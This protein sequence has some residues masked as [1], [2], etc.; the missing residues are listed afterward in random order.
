[1]VMEHRRCRVALAAVA[2]VFPL[3]A[4]AQEPIETA[5]RDTV[6]AIDASP[7]WAST[8]ASVSYDAATDTA[9]VSGLSV[10]SERPGADFAIETMKIAGYA[11][12]ANG[13]FTTRSITIDS[14]VVEA[15]FAKFAISD[16]TLDRLAAP[17]FAAIAF[18]QNKPFTSMMRIYADV[19][20]TRLASGQIGMLELV[21]Q[22]EGITSRASYENLRFDG[23]ADGKVASMT[24]GPLKMDSPSEQGLVKM[25]FGSVEGRDLDLAAFVHVYS[26]DSYPNGVGDMVWRNGMALAAYNNVEVEVPGARIAFG[27]IRL[28]DFRLRQPR[29]SFGEFFDRIMVNPNMSDH[30]ADQLAKAH[31]VDM[32]SAFGI[33]RFAIDRM[34]IAAQGLDRFRME[35]FHIS[36]LS[37]GGLGEFAIDG[38]DLAVPDQGEAVIGRFAFGGMVFPSP[39]AMQLAIDRADTDQPPDPKTLIP[40]LG[41]FEVL[42]LDL[43]PTGKDAIALGKFRFDLSDYLGV[44]PTR[45]VTEMV[46]LI[47][48]LSTIDD[49]DARAMFARLGYQTLDASYGFDLRWNPADETLKLQDLRA[50]VKG[51]GSL[52][53][54]VTL[55]G[56]PRQFLET[57]EL[58]AMAI[59]GLSLIDASFTF[60]DDSIVGKGL[61]LL[62]EQMK[63]PPDRFRQQ[64]ADAMPF[65][66]SMSALNDPKLMAIVQQSGLLARLAPVVK[67]FVASPGASV[68][69]TLAPP[70]P[71]SLAAIGEAS[72]KAPNTL[73]QVLGLSVSGKA[74]PTPTP[75]PAPTVDTPARVDPSPATGGGTETDP[76]RKPGEPAN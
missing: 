50:A 58:L 36:D 71:L 45:I 73:V 17:A 30:A 49:A 26:P 34:E 51:V 54:D 57:P 23:F 39:E 42:G 74:P 11:V 3:P 59:P 10:R 12:A 76:M 61:D 72:E 38:L 19:I 29:K 66:L 47:V 20:R 55:A 15:G 41:F 75:D 14:A 35:G 22:F 65:L 31:V 64:F 13:G 62:A 6:A 69:V 40:T 70:S 32:F 68:T 53:A 1:M 60:T 25:Q 43:R 33:G 5:I 63:A 67:E 24:A 7:D 56:L 44:I 9:T 52:T 28:E 4:V 16:V 27:S 46:G 21:Q 2:L 18:D 48:P 37:I 8:V